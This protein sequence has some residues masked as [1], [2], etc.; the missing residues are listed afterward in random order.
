MSS[1]V[2]SLYP[3]FNFLAFS[4]VSSLTSFI[5][6]FFMALKYLDGFVLLPNLN[7]AIS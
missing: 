7:S 3:I 1:T 6:L 2:G 4:T 5:I